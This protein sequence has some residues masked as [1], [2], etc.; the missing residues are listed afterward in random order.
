MDPSFFS[1][2]ESQKIKVMTE[3]RFV[4]SVSV[5]QLPEKLDPQ[6]PSFRIKIWKTH[7]SYFFE[8]C[9]GYEPSCSGYRYWYN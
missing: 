2:I 9:L 7:D 4:R 5:G 3:R 8:R 6:C 1:E